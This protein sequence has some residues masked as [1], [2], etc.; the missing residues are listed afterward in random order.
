MTFDHVYAT[1]LV[2]L[3]LMQNIPSKSLLLIALIQIPQVPHIRTVAFLSRADIPEFKLLGL[4][5]RENYTDRAAA[6]SRRSSFQNLCNFNLSSFKKKFKRYNRE[7]TTFFKRAEF[8]LWG[9]QEQCQEIGRRI[10]YAVVPFRCDRTAF[11]QL[12]LG[13]QLDFQRYLC[14]ADY[15]YAHFRHAQNSACAGSSGQ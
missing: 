7:L 13:L 14:I 15:L 3:R 5:P 10:T 9:V 6:A 2:P 8:F 11:R 1:I 4:S 12:P